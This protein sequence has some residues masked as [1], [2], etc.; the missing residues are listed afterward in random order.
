MFM[1]LRIVEDFYD[2]E[3]VVNSEPVYGY[4]FYNHMTDEDFFLIGHY[5]DKVARYGKELADI[6]SG[7]PDDMQNRLDDFYYRLPK[8][9]DVTDPEYDTCEYQRLTN[10][11]VVETDDFTY[12]VIVVGDYSGRF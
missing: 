4:H 3:E 9:L 5:E 10:S 6:Y 1:K 7:N 8:Y 12:E 2:D 11:W